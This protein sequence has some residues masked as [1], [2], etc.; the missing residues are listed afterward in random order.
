MNFNEVAEFRPDVEE[1]IQ[2]DFTAHPGSWRKDEQGWY[3]EGW[4]RNHHLLQETIAQ[5]DQA[6]YELEKA[7]SEVF[8][9]EGILAIKPNQLEN[10][11]DEARAETRALLDELGRSHPA[12]WPRLVSEMRKNL[13][14]DDAAQPLTKV[15]NMWPRRVMSPDDVEIGQWLLYVWKDQWSTSQVESLDVEGWDLAERPVYVL[16]NPA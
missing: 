6:L 9:L 10:E 2:A 5:R 1:Q 13:G 12:Q 15:L 4:L 14:T 7:R 11:R 16:P 3:R 8:R